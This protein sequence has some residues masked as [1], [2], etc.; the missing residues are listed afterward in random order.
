MT[1]NIRQAGPA[2][3]LA[4]E[5]VLT[6]YREAIEPSE[7]RP[8]AGLRASLARADYRLIIAERH[9]EIVGFSISYA[10]V[11]EDFWL[12]EYAATIAAE[13]GQ[14][15]GTMLFSQAGVSAG[16]ERIALVEVDAIPPGGGE[17]QEK[18]LRFY[19]RLGCRIVLGVD[20][21]L[22]L[23]ANGTPPPMLLLALAPPGMAG[24]S[25]E[26]LKRWLT[27]LYTGVY[28]KLA[29]DPRIGLMLHGL[30]LDIALAPISLDRATP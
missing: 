25:R 30:A 18:R 8:E 9:G 14:G 7:Q 16:I 1:L 13:R 6:I 21:I 5:R 10:P 12:F 29:D 27:Q 22:P 23:E 2:D 17:V 20:Y 3:S 26:T 24:V 11:G 15:T 19:Q 28:G 4:M